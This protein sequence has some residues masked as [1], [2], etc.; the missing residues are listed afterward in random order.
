[1]DQSKWRFDVEL[2]L[3]DTG[4][5][6]LLVDLR[7]HFRP[8][9]PGTRVLITVRDAGAPIELPA[10]CRLTG[11]RLLTADHPRYLVEKV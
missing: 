3:G 1:V 9:S 11:H 8:L 2:D 6:E 10:W 4:C 7:Y 5:G